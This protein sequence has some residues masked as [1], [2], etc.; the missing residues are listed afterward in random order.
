MSDFKSGFINIIGNPNVGKSTLMNALV[1]ER[2]SI[3]TSKAQT[4][5]HRIL[6]ILNGE[7]FQMIYSDT[8]GIISNPQYKLQESMNKFVSG[9]LKD[10]D[11]LIYVTDIFEYEEEEKRNLFLDK[12]AS[13]DFTIPTYLVI[14]KVDLDNKG[15]LDEVVDYWSQ[16][17][18][19]TEIIPISA[20]EK[21]NLET[22]FDRLLEKLPVHP[23]YYDVDA[24]TDKP[25][26][27]FISEIIREKIFQNYTK[28][29]PYS[30]QVEVESFNETEDKIYIQAII[31]VERNSQKGIVIG[32]GGAALRKVGIAACK[33]AEQFLMKQVDLRLFVKVRDKW[34]SNT[35]DLKGFGYTE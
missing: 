16:H 1:G 30:T 3:I 20:L 13:S 17:G 21:F 29:V 6:G 32:K 33:D 19:F 8:P 14:N 2:L 23:P 9:S 28:E 18:E 10:A 27:F 25:E 22:L 12:I 31:F 26:R 35:N 5:R 7:D 4:T 15:K 24:L 11:V 34:R